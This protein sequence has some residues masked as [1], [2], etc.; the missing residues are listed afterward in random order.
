MTGKKSFT[1][2]AS[3]PMPLDTFLSEAK[4]HC[5]TLE[6]KDAAL[7]NAYRIFAYSMDISTEQHRQINS[8][9]Q[10]VGEAMEE[11]C[12]LLS[13][14]ESLPQSAR[15]YRYL[16]LVTFQYMHGQVQAILSALASM[17][18]LRKT[19]SLQ[20]DRLKLVI[21]HKLKALRQDLQEGLRHIRDLAD[22]AQLEEKRMNRLSS[23]QQQKLFVISGT[24]LSKE[25]KRDGREPSMGQL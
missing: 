7:F 22:Q 21:N 15:S 4:T 23:T 14:A 16:P 5:Q 10:Q 11:L 8:L 17:H 6:S 12:L 3:T 20:K 25:K 13:D 24:R 1:L 18:Q 19:S 2:R 9:I